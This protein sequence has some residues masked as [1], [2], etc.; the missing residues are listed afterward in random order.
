MAGKATGPAHRARGAR[1]RDAGPDV[2]AAELV[3]ELFAHADEILAREEY[4]GIGDAPSFHT[5]LAGVTFE[6][7]QDVVAR[8]V[9]GY[10]A[11]AWSGSPTTRTTRTPARCSTV[12]GDQVGFFNRRLAAALAPAIDA[13][14]DYE[15]EV[16]DITGGER[17]SAAGV[18]VLVSRRDAM[19]G[20]EDDRRACASATRAELAALPAE[21]ARGGA[22]AALHRRPHARTR[23]RRE[24]LGAPGERAT[25]RSP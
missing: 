2:P 9:P 20:A 7:R 14:V 11:C 15:V 19:T 24:A 6:G 13:G 12:T 16:T 18:N 17:R 1:Q 25:T 21:R 5:K 22:R 10:A 23:R 4:A 8:L 3:E